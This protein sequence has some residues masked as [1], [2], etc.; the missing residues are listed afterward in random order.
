[1]AA[2]KTTTQRGLGHAH[3]QQVKSLKAKHTDGSPCWWC[4]LPMWLD[5]ALNWDGQT[6]AG[7]H[8]RSRALHT[9]TK[10]DRL[11][12]GICNKRRGAGLKDH[13]RPAVTGDP[14]DAPLDT[15]VDDRS[16]WCAMAW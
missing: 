14:P 8:S 7:D 13:L 15:E 10:A 16:Q 5:D 12:H 3:R 2:K 6:L 4:G 11:L 1:M 9:G